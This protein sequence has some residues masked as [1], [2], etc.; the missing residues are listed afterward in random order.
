[1][2]DA[3]DVLRL[4]PEA[5]EEDIKKSF[6]RMSL[7]YHP[8]K[9]QASGN[10]LDSTT[11]GE[12]FHEIKLAY[13]ILQDADRR[14]MYDTFGIDLGEE[15]PEMEV[16]TIGLGTMLSPLGAFAL[17]TLLTRLAIWFIG[18]KWVGRILMLCGCTVGALYAADFSFRE[19]SIR[20][21]DVAPILVQIGIVDAVV[22]LYWI[23]PLLADTVGVVYLLSEV[24]GAAPLLDS[25]QLAVGALV[26][27][28]VV[29]RLTRGWWLWILGLE[30]LLAV[31]LLVAL[32]V[33]AGI[34][35]LWI[36]GVQA[37]RCEKL[38]DWRLAMRKH[39]KELQDEI[40]LLKRRLGERGAPP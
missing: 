9:L 17:K 25:W 29:A 22:L 37:Q 13:D 5:S 34:M 16:W 8:D 14:K 12:K 30:V 21:R 18:F 2:I 11:A 36:D 7:Q 15:R 28:L 20:S 38:R 3:Y 24:V 19:V 23:W 1:M 35:R 33:A 26:G 6:K 4:G 40:D 31:V 39:R 10:H 32:T 27:S